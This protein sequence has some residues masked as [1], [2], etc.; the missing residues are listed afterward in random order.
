MAR[1]NKC[2]GLVKVI[3]CN[4]NPVVIK[5]ILDYLKNKTATN[6]PSPLTESR[7]SA[8]G[9]QQGLFV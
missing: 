8:A 2:G 9:L 7:V 5:Q 4:E 6:E 3:V 1:E